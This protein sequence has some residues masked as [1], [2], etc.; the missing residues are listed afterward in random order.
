M[1]LQLRPLEEH[2]IPLV[3]AWFYLPH[4]RQ[5]FEHPQNWLRG[6]HGRHGPY[7]YI[8]HYIG[9]LRGAPIAFGQ[10]ADC[11]LAPPGPWSR[12]PAG[13]YGI[14]YLIGEPSALHRGFGL[15]LVNALCAFACKQHQAIQIVADPITEAGR[16]NEASIRTLIA[17]GFA[18]NPKTNLY[19]KPTFSLSM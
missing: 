16:R 8:R 7:A 6:I 10:Y 1:R 12:E 14:D 2:D 11:A 4:V 18:F 5:W 17:C 9:V 19:H 13:T 15:Q 3:C